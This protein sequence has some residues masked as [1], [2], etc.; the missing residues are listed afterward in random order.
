MQALRSWPPAATLSPPCGPGPSVFTAHAKK[1]MGRASVSRASGRRG[2]PPLP[3]MSLGACTC[4]SAGRQG[5]DELARKAESAG[6][7]TIGLRPTGGGGRAPIRPEENFAT[8]VYFL[9]EWCV[10]SPR[11]DGVADDRTRWPISV[12]APL[13]PR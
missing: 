12:A 13:I 7:R 4:R 10:K 6:R 8:A 5:R 2:A 1:G 11:T 9:M 3:A